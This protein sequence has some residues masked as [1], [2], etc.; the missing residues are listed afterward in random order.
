MLMQLNGMKVFG[1]K[2]IS[3]LERDRKSILM[4]PSSLASL[5]ME[6]GRER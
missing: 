1:F 4:E 6:F 3:V 5:Y 2:I